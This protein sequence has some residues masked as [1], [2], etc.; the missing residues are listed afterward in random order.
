[1]ADLNS[2]EEGKSIC[3]Y[4]GKEMYESSIYEKRT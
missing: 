1:M 4:L 3:F 2:F